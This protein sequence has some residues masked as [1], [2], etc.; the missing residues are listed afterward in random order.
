ML[1]GVRLEASDG[2]VSI[3]ATD[4]ELSAR[5][6]VHGAVTVDGAG[7]VVIP[8][9]GLV[10]AV[11]AMGELEIVLESR[12]S[13]GQAGL[14]VRAGTRTVSLQGWP[15]EEWPAVPQ[16]AAIDPIASIE[17]SAVVD[18]FERV[19]LCASSDE[20]RPVL[21]C[22]ALFFRGDPAALEVV[23]TDSYRLGVARLPLE[24]GFRV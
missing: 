4:L 16:M 19:A 6:V 24:A 15:S 13:D 3:E 7:S 23:A 21:T 12:S 18:A 5:R 2:E 20:A 9:K 10:K 14:D 1:S 8:A 11:A 17:A 22:A